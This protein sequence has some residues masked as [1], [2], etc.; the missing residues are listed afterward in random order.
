MGLHLYLSNTERAIRALFEGIDQYHAEYDFLKELP[1]SPPE[2]NEEAW[3][4]YSRKGH[5]AVEEILALS[6]L[7]GSILQ[8]AFA[9]IKQF[10]KVP[11]RT[12]SE[13]E[14]LT[15]SGARKKFLFGR[16]VRGIPLG[17]VVLAGRNQHCH[18]EEE[19]PHKLTQQV[20][21][22][23]ATRC[24]GGERD[25]RFCLSTLMSEGGVPIRNAAAA[26]LNVLE[27]TTF[28]KVVEDLQECVN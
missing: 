25:T 16:E 18:Y 1:P 14:G 9:G 10:G 8:I 28:E 4:N 22:A 11:D 13:W 23:L 17:I 12:T 3:S 24:E 21:E 2:E 7:S 20:F 6:Y 27:W 15:K 19:K 26:I 5:M